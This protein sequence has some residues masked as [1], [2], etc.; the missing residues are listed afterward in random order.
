M[1]ILC[2]AI[3]LLEREALRESQWNKLILSDDASFGIMTAWR[4]SQKPTEN[5]RRN[6]Q[7]V[8]DFGERSWRYQAVRGVFPE[9]QDKGVKI[10]FE[11]SFLIWDPEYLDLLSLGEKYEQE[12]VIFKPLDGPMGY[13]DLKAGTVAV[14]TGHKTTPN[15]PG[16]PQQKEKRRQ[17]LRKYEDKAR[18]YKE[19][20]SAEYPGFP[21]PD[22]DP[23]TLDR[24][25][26]V[27]TSF[28]FSNPLSL[29]SEPITYE[30]HPEL[31]T[32]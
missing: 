23:M 30:N 20:P 8:R 6:D 16:I 25:L 28:D 13:Y 11:K 12:A 31:R 27:R 15:Q 14:Y 32:P 29:G 24:N 21:P 17:D 10:A 22:P 26:E 9:V 1:H 3:D 2:R 5:H 19:D 18:R 7:L 4:Q